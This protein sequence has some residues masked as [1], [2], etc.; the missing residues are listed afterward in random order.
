MRFKEI[1]IF[2]ITIGVHYHI[3]FI[4]AT[5]LYRHSRPCF[6][7]YLLCN[8][9]STELFKN[10]NQVMPLLS[11]SNGFCDPQNKSKCIAL[12]CRVTLALF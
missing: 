5:L 3:S 7:W 8:Q 4:K 1:N 2:R 11:P 10:V 12:A 9:F 6:H